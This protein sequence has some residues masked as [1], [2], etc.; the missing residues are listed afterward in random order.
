MGEVYRSRDRGA[1]WKRMQG[2]LEQKGSRHIDAAV[3]D[4]RNPGINKF[5]GRHSY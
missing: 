4:V 5:K 1:S 2:I 3:P